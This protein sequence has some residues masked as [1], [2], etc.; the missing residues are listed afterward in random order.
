MEK[1]LAGIQKKNLIA[2]D[3]N[4]ESFIL[5]EK[6]NNNLI[7]FSFFLLILS[8]YF[9]SSAIFEFDTPENALKAVES[10]ND[11]QLDKNHTLKFYTVEAFDKIMK[12][13]NIYLPPKILKKSDL[14][15]WLLDSEF[16]DQY[17]FHMQKGTSK[18]F[19]NWF[20]HL[21]KKPTNAISSEN[22]ETNEVVGVDWSQ[23]GS[24]LILLNK[25]V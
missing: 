9:L 7:D 13:S 19:V 14:Q 17:F 6:T 23:N 10:L 20:D 4:N 12:T 22:L 3:K 5:L 15:K 18:I 2:F 11:T 16:R 21:E 24:Y 25:L 1:Q 8:I